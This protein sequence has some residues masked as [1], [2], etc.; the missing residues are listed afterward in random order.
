MAVLG[1]GSARTSTAITLARAG[2]SITLLERCRDE[3]T[4]VGETLPRDIRGP[5]TELGVWE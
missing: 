2:S 3:S 4:R 1:G 5:L